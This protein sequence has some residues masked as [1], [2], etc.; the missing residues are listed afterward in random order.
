MKTKLSKER[1]KAL[2]FVKSEGKRGRKQ[3]FTNRR[4]KLFAMEKSIIIYP[5]ISRT[6]TFSCK[7]SKRAE[8][9]RG[10]AAPTAAGFV[11]VTPFRRASESNLVFTVAIAQSARQPRT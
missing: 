4:R 11:K 3:K 8:I 10:R 6:V 2:R 1:K 7:T 9:A 5:G